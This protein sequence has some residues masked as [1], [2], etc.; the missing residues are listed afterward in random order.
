[1]TKQNLG[2][3][4]VGNTSKHVRI[5]KVFFKNSFGIH[6]HLMNKS[7]VEATGEIYESFCADD[8]L[9]G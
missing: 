8:Q 7:S 9:E 6:K 1:M 4:T 5:I 3:L 2:E